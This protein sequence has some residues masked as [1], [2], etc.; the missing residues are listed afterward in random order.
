MSIKSKTTMLA[1][2]LFFLLP[3]PPRAL[4]DGQLDVTETTRGGKPVISVENPFYEVLIAPERGALIESFRL[5]PC[6]TECT[7]FR[8]GDFGGLLQEVNTAEMPYEM[9]EKKT[10]DDKA[11]FVFTSPAA[12]YSVEKKMIFR[13]NAPHIEITFTFENRSELSL[14]GLQA[15]AISNVFRGS[16]ERGGPAGHYY[17]TGG[18]YGTDTFT[19]TKALRRHHPLLDLRREPVT[20]LAAIDPVRE[21]G[22]AVVFLDTGVENIF[23]GRNSRGFAS[24]EMQFR[25]LPARSRL[26]S[27]WLL[28]PLK[29]FSSVDSINAD[30]IAETSHMRS[31]GKDKLSVRVMSLMQKTKDISIVTRAYNHKGEELGPLETI[32]FDNMSRGEPENATIYAEGREPGD[33]AWL[34][35]EIYANGSRKKRYLVRV[36]ESDTAPDIRAEQPPQPAVEELETEGEKETQNQEQNDVADTP[37]I[38][39]RQLAGLRWAEMNKV[40]LSMA[41]NTLQTLVF[42]IDAGENI[43]DLQIGTIPAPSEE[44][45]G[46]IKA[47]TA[48]NVFLWEVTEPNS[49][50]AGLV[51]LRRQDIDAGEPALFAVTIDSS[52]LEKGAYRAVLLVSTVPKTLEIPLKIRVFPVTAAPSEGF[53]LWHIGPD[54]SKI[55]QTAFGKLRRYSVNAASYGFTG[56]TELPAMKHL[57]G[58]AA[59]HDMDMAGF[60]SPGMAEIYAEKAA[61]MG[62]DTSPPPPQTPWIICMAADGTETKETARELGFA[63]AAF[64]RRLSP[65][66]LSELS[67]QNGFEH[68]IFGGDVPSVN[69]NIQGGDLFTSATNAHLWRYIDLRSRHWQELAVHAREEFYNALL[70]GAQGAAIRGKPPAI[71]SRDRMLLWHLIRDVREE[72]ALLAM[73]IEAVDDPEVPESLRNKLKA[74]TSGD[75]NSPVKIGGKQGAFGDAAYIDIDR[76]RSHLIG[77]QMRRLALEILSRR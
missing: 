23:A 2:F 4:A 33:I 59:E 68:I 3:G 38:T 11:I 54:E 48:T 34:R 30:F 26:T 64:V 18:A 72:A 73:A 56:A 7:F 15:P 22:I 46:Q 75:E 70:S 51:P 43:D 63:P 53:Q 42:R 61:Q 5:K 52:R 9:T 17:N 65:A 19:E 41:E 66:L 60:Y 76:S 28:M 36:A 77:E 55:A 69:N 45:N 50:K 47:L 35:H 6:G 24:V 20:W 57:K 44:E 67:R 8:A 37:H 29:N 40:E 10:G 12:D 14:R 32:V 16:A 27:K 74:L 71:G 58:T 31:A 25:N 62:F 49:T 1:F 39:A 21:T 13:P